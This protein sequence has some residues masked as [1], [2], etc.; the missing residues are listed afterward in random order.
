MTI[1]YGNGTTTTAVAANQA[2]YV[3]SMFMDATNGQVTC[4]TSY[5][6]N[7]KFGVWNAYNRVPITLQAGDST[8]S[9]TYGTTTIRASNN[10][11][12]SY[13][14]N[15]YNV[16]SGTTCN[17]MT[18]LTGLPEEQ[19]A[20]TLSQFLFNNNSAGAITMSAGVGLNSTTAYSGTIATLSVEPQNGGALTASYS[21]PISLGI[22]VVA[23]LEEGLSGG[24]LTVFHGTQTNMLLQ[25]QW[26]G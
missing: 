2:T 1:R 21:P 23:S 4:H 14:A 6:Q 12:S 22:I 8:A 3:G 17:G 26:R 24:N 11:P 9:W 16:G 13:S 10:N 19:A 18:V 5:G 20:V 7:R 25:A 15:S